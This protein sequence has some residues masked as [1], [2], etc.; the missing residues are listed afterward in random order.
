M[1]YS[2]LFI[3]LACLVF[4]E[5]YPTSV[6]LYKPRPTGSVRTK[7]TSVQYSPVKTSRSVNKKLLYY[8]LI[9]AHTP[10]IKVS[11][12]RSVQHIVTTV[13]FWIVGQRKSRACSNRGRTFNV[14]YWTSECT[15]GVIERVGGGGVGGTVA[16][17]PRVFR[18]NHM[19]EE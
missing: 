12:H 4:T 10:Y 14:S 1:P 18:L 2:K 5:K 16:H 17:M 13:L 3:N 15:A 19:W 6:F 8:L 11:T 7:K 9:F